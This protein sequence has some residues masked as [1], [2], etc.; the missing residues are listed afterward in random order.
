MTES[1]TA[2]TLNRAIPIYVGYGM[3]PDPIPDF[4]RVVERFGDAVWRL[5]PDLEE[6]VQ[7]LDHIEPS[8]R[9][10]GQHADGVWAVSLLREMYPFLNAEACEALAWCWSRRNL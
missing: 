4:Q 2:S 7:E 10:D 6:V 1:S 8:L 3:L 5:R 9:K